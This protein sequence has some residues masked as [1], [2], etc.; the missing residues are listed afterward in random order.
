MCSDQRL[1]GFTS[2]STTHTVTRDLRK[3][4]ADAARTENTPMRGEGSGLL[5]PGRVLQNEQVKLCAESSKAA[6]MQKIGWTALQI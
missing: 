1:S 3:C 2:A 6:S 5:E 4:N